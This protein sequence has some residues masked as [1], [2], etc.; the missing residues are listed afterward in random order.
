VTAIQTGHPGSDAFSDTDGVACIDGVVIRV[1]K[2]ERVT[3]D[4]TYVSYEIRLPGTQAP[5]CGTL[6]VEHPSSMSELDTA[7][8]ERASDAVEQAGL[9]ACVMERVTYV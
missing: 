2:T 3:N 1:V 6:A 5:V 4:E 7:L 8:R 9:P